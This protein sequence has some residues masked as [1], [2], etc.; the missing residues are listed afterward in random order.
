MTAQ[1]PPQVNDDNR[2]VRGLCYAVVLTSCGRFDLLR[3][4]VASFAK[5]ADIAPQQFI[6]VEDSDDGQVREAVAGINLPFEFVITPRLGQAKAIDA[7]YARVK[8]PYVFHCEDDWAFFRGGFIAESFAVLS[9]CPKASAVMLR[10][11][12]E[13]HSFGKLPYENT[14]G[15]DF[16]LALPT[17]H[18]YYF[19]YSYNP[20]LRRLADYKSI[21]PFADIGTEREVS[22]V[23]K[24]LGFITAHLEAPAVRH[25]GDNRHVPDAAE[26]P[27]NLRWKRKIHRWRL[28][29][30]I[31]IW[32][33]FGL[34]KRLQQ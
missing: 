21:A 10:G 11:R 18:K 15:V 24:R 17:L 19:G 25:L 5:Y 22:F 3:Q 9:A 34:P 30:K 28:R 6:I 7:G 4:T 29:L 32:R 14:D 12:D 20:G 23:F 31:K 33:V 16:F 1:P 8:T 26:P 13:N 2:I 27:R